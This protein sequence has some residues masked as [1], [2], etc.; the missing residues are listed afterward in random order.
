[1]YEVEV[2]GEEGKMYS[3]TS[4]SRLFSWME[5]DIKGREPV[6]NYLVTQKGNQDMDNSVDSVV[7]FKKRSL[8]EKDLSLVAPKVSVVG[9]RILEDGWELVLEGPANQV[10]D[11]IYFWG[12]EQER[13]G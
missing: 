5:E 6:T 13:N 7:I 12:R 9:S 1:M 2:M 10:E 4:L 8:I 3:F 11:I